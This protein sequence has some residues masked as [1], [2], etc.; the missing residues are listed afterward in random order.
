MKFLFGN[1][2]IDNI[3]LTEVRD[4]IVET[5]KGGSKGYII[6]SNAAHIV[7]LRKDREFEEAYKNALLVLPDGISIMW[8][9]KLLGCPLKERITGTNLFELSSSLA[10]QKN[11][12]V[13]L[14]GAED[15]VVERVAKNLRHK[16]TNL[17]IAGYHNGYFENDREVINKINAAAPDILF[18]AIGFPKQEK[19]VY[20]YLDMLDVKVAICIG[21]VFDIAANKTK[22]A[23]QRLQKM[24]LE[25]F[26]RLIQE[27]RRLWRRYLVGNTIFIFLL[28]KELFKK[29][30]WR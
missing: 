8:S 20:K 26:W 13:F 28:S 18:V 3:H 4:K 23:S 6:T 30:F 21:G 7:C 16:F 25:W 24:G 29:Y 9:S 11:Y 15:Y 10:S 2:K 12:S 1:A 22:R 17:Q 14:L 19:W 5:I 27:P